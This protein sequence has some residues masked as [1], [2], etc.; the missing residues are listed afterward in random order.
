MLPVGEGSPGCLGGSPSRGS[1]RGSGRGSW[2]GSGRGSGR[3]SRRRGPG[4]GRR[5]G[6]VA[7]EGARGERGG[8]GE[9]CRRLAKLSL[10]ESSSQKLPLVAVE[11][12]AGVEFPV[13]DRSSCTAIM[14]QEKDTVSE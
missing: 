11:D 2:R 5:E 10:R 6:V 12:R 7:A 1:W 4:G 9:G 13:S 8:G 3:G 14:V